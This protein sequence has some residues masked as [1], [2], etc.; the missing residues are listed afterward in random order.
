M[1]AV[2]TLSNKLMHINC[3][4]IKSV[5][6][7]PDTIII[8]LDGSALPVKESVQ[9]VVQRIIEYKRAIRRDLGSV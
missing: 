2:T 3:E 9:E 4:Q 6:P 8:F 5:K 1:I 7:T